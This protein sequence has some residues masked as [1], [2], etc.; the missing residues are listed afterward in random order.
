MA[1][2][3]NDV[4]Q[5]QYGWQT[6]SDVSRAMIG[7]GSAGQNRIS[8]GMKAAWEAKTGSMF[9]G[10]DTTKVARVLRL[11]GKQNAAKWYDRF[12]ATEKKTKRGSRS[13]D[14]QDAGSSSS[15]ST[16]I[17]AV[18][19]NTGLLKAQ[20]R[21]LDAMHGLIDLI[22]DDVSNMK[23][24]FSPKTTA[25]KGTSGK[26]RNVQF[27][28]L[29]PAGSQFQEVTS[30]GALTYKKLS[31]VDKSNAGRRIAIESAK[32]VLK[33][34]E[35]EK[36]K[37]ELR[38]KFAWKDE[39][40]KFKVEEPLEEVK[41]RL[42]S[43]EQ[44]LEELKEKP[45]IFDLFKN[46]LSGIASSF[47][48]LLSG[49]GIAAIGYA[50]GSWINDK[51]KVS[52]KIGDSIDW[53]KKKLGIGWEARDE[54]MM[55]NHTFKAIADRN[56]KLLEGTGFQH[57][58]TGTFQD[59]SGKTYSHDELPAEIQKLIEKTPPPP[60]AT[61]T[62]TAPASTGELRKQGPATEADLLNLIAKGEGTTDEKAK[63]KGFDS[64][65]D[66]TLDY[67]RWHKKPAVPLSK[68]TMAQ[69]NYLQDEM[70]ATQKKEGR[71]GAPSSAVGR[72]QIVRSTLFGQKGVAGS[73]YPYGGLF[74]QLGLKR[75]DIFTPELQDRLASRLLETRGLSKLKGNTMDTATFQK[76]LSK[77]WASIA[78]PSTGKSH[79]GQAT[80]VSTSEIQPV[81]SALGK[82][83]D[84]ASRSMQ[85]SNSPSNVT[86]VAPQQQQT[87]IA[88]APASAPPRPVQKASALPDDSSFIRN[89]VR[90]VQH[91][92]MAG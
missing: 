32:I 39:D 13:Y 84:Q 60:K 43:I 29:A 52:E 46:L 70:I 21:R 65:Y 47:K 66:V 85:A 45:S 23:S 77:E 59:A 78:D 20:G 9:S 27:N 57:V 31:E 28:P 7:A 53:V 92:T 63:S 89:A 86:I 54:E 50:I 73:N 72:Y 18:K 67:G 62:P 48:W 19:L 58:A 55:K 61:T 40:E 17:S 26:N 37:G 14:Q 24:M 2:K 22:A 74:G 90:D 81:I 51:F 8:A 25:I 34:V 33:V 44:A 69:V 88:S 83:V 71:P 36:K 49:A 3:D 80:G 30:S 10:S 12:F 4:A 16:L 56:N 91:P 15:S 87:V 64:G 1:K 75:S 6:T 42:Y 5:Q 79:Y 41:E 82:Q 68:M 76:E 38:K 11:L 35:E